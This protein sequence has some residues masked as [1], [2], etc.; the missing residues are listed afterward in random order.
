MIQLIK[1]S[2]ISNT[3]GGYKRR[4][5]LF[6]EWKRT[7]ILTLELLSCHFYLCMDPAGRWQL[8]HSYI[9]CVSINHLASMFSVN[10]DTVDVFLS[11]C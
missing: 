5:D 2:Y 3:K 6:D 7:L 10:K 9:S 8:C 1:K 4:L 11:L